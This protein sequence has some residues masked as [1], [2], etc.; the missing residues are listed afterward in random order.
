LLFKHKAKALKKLQSRGTA[1]S[2]EINK[3]QEGF[4]KIS[5]MNQAIED[6]KTITDPK[7]RVDR[8]DEL[9]DQ[10]DALKKEMADNAETLT[11]YK[12][13]A[14]NPDGINKIQKGCGRQ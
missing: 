9:I 6:L 14:R 1:I 3:A 12:K 8:I 2:G 13:I 5:Q 10:Y 7:A 11:G 4:D